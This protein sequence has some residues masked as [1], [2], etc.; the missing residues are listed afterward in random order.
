M[1]SS[2][3]ADVSRQIAGK[4]ARRSHVALLMHEPVPALSMVIPAYS[5]P[6][7][8]MAACIR[9]LARQISNVEYEVILGLA[10]AGC[11]TSDSVDRPPRQNWPST[12]WA[13]SHAD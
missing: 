8:R 5:E 2:P 3:L 10:P 12:A 11:G 4:I 13:R 9:S 1:A 6:R 7:W